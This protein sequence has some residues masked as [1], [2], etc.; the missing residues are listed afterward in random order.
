MRLNDTAALV[1]GGASGLGCATARVLAER[2]VRVFALDVPKAVDDAPV[3][4]G[5]TY[6]EADVT[7]PAQVQ[8]AVEHAV[9]CGLPLRTAVNCAGISA[10]MPILSD[11]G[12]HDLALFRR[13]VEINLIGT[14]NVMALVAEA[15]AKTEPLADGARGVIIN[16]TSIGAFDGTTGTAAYTASK[17]GVAGLTLPSARDLAPHGIRVMAIAPGTFNTP[18]LGM[19]MASEEFL[20]AVGANVPFPKRVGR[21][22][23]FAQLVID[24]IEHDYLNGEVIRLDGALRLSS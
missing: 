1:T 21:P 20:A 15:I 23:E 3:V 19:G 11:Q 9:G 22:D 18:M 7:E 16:T 4:D 8:T 14:F 24:I 2:G 17:S 12:H 10:F 6:V 5:V 13:V